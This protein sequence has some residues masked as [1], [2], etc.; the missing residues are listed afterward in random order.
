MKKNT[1][2]LL[3]LLLSIGTIHAQFG[4]NTSVFSVKPLTAK[5]TF[6][7]DGVVVGDL[8]KVF[9]EKEKADGS[10][11]DVSV[12]HI[13]AYKIGSST[14]KNS[15]TS[16]IADG[17]TPLTVFKK[18]GA[19][20]IEKGMEIKKIK[21]NKISYGAEY[22]FQK[23]TF[24][25]GPTILASAKGATGGFSF[26]IATNLKF[27]TNSPLNYNGQ[28][29]NYDIKSWVSIGLRG[30]KVLL[31]LNYFQ[32]SAV[33]G[34]FGCALSV[35]DIGKTTINA[36]Y[37]DGSSAPWYGFGGVKLS[38]N[39]GPRFQFFIQDFYTTQL[40]PDKWTMTYYGGASSTSN[41]EA[42]LKNNLNYKRNSVNFGFRIR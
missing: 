35:N 27:E 25:S 30:E 24:F 19:R 36:N 32:L 13:M 17:N 20:N 14:L 28:T 15:K 16:L 2:L 21:R 29:K 6:E 39:V 11:K 10:S 3:L 23:N 41:L 22:S 31:F 9:Y 5:V 37:A 38:L 34:A 4:L 33:V 8:Y 42:Q 12:G 26:F 1:P 18:I 40:V 7:K